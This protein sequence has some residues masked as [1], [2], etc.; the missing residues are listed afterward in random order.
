VIEDRDPRIVAGSDY[1]NPDPE[2]KR[3]D[4]RQHRRSVEL[5]GS[6][7]NYVEIGEGKPV[8][9]V[10]GLSGCW[11]NWLENLPHFGRTQRSI[12]ID[13]PGFGSSPMPRWEIDMPA[14]GRLVHDFCERL[15]LEDVVLVGHSM[16][17]FIAVETVTEFPR[18]FERLALVSAAGILNTWNPE[19][20]ATVTAYAWRRFGPTV[21]DRGHWIV[22]HPRSRKLA[23]APFFRYPNRLGAELMLEQVE[24]GARCPAFGPA[25]KALIRRDIRERLTRIEM[26]TL[27]VWGLSDRVIPVAAA[28]SYHRRIP[29]SRL[30][31]FER[32]GHL[33]QLERPDRFN[34]V[35]DEW[36][37]EQRTLDGG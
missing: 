37:V 13:L 22:S 36:L 3:I 10:H 9:F 25:L 6:K 1:G 5:D 32:T 14:Y 17:G 12:A 30:E 15:G 24:G 2:W 18:R 28:I 35:L 23:L 16:G 31:I 29:Q 33:P 19:E 26:P 7:V 20:R 4:W 21:A 8:L 27:V 34:A 11:Q